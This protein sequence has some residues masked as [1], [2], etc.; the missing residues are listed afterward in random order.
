MATQ[1]ISSPPLSQGPKRRRRFQGLLMAATL[2]CAGSNAAQSGKDQVGW[3]DKS[4]RAKTW[5]GIILENT[6]KQT[7]IQ[8]GDKT[9]T[10]ESS[11]VTSVSF[12]TV[13]PAFSEGVAYFERRDFETAAARFQVAATDASASEAVKAAARFRAGE[14]WMQAGATAASAFTSAADQLERLKSDFPEAR[15]LPRATLYLGRAKWLGG[16]AKG[17]A[18]LLRAL[19][20]EREK[21]GYGANVCYR[22]GVFASQAYTAAGDTKTAKTV[23]DAVLPALASSLA[24]LDDSDELRFELGNIEADALLGE[25]F[26]LLADGKTSQA[27]NFFRSK[28]SATSKSEALQFGARLGLGEALLAGGDTRE[29]Q[30]EFS[31]VSAL[32][33]TSND[34]VARALIGLTECALKLPDS[35]SRQNAKLWLQSIIDQ[36]GDT[37]SV[38]RAKELSKSL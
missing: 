33:H 20:Q 3:V 22:A 7:V 9:R 31:M 10:T 6:L 11:A 15:V 26:C 2:L 27:K 29:A 37:P 25:G 13:P 12:G 19:F 8:V 18:D 23:L 1:S 28:L 24:S 32:D 34:R 36:F 5:T 17:C 16:D 30:I 21:P 4:G 14:S 38:L 35:D